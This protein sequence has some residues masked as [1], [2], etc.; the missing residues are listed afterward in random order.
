MQAQVPSA[1]RA[2]DM[3]LLRER[4]AFALY[5]SGVRAQ[6]QPQRP[7]DPAPTDTTPA[8]AVSV[9]PESSSTWDWDCV[10]LHETGADW[11]A[12]G[13]S[14]SSALGV[15]NQAVR[16]NAPA[17]VAARILAGTASR[18]EQID[19]AQGIVNRFGVNAWAASTVAY[20]T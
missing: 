20:C 9:A 8:H 19:M 1:L 4:Y 7:A 10:A 14:Y 2:A 15:M 12:H 11:T 5:L 17:D 6:V 16:E 18:Q 13:S 3:A